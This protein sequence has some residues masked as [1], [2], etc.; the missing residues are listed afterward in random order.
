MQIN[1]FH[2]KITN[3]GLEFKSDAHKRLFKKWL[4]QF[5]GKEVQ[6]EILPKRSKR[7]DNQN[8]YYWMY[9][10]LISSETG[11]TEDELHAFFKGKFLTKRITEILGE[12]TR[13]TKST[14]ELSRGEFC[15]YLVEISQL[16][17]I[18]LPDTTEFFGYSYHK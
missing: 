17:Q 5:E 15:D 18:E 4:N 11:H 10:G 12:K 1:T 13:I 16:T 9:L 14:T 6:L 2:I 8:R 3:G 7:S